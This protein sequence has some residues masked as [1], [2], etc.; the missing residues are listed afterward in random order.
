MATSPFNGLMAVHR[1]TTIFIPLPRELWTV[2]DGGYS[3]GVC[4]ERAGIAPGVPF[5]GTAYWDTL[6]VSTEPDRKGGKTSH[7]ATVHYPELHA[8][9][10]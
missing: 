9:E 3:C 6:A 2:I 10:S 1:G 5:T 4:R 7:T 8:K